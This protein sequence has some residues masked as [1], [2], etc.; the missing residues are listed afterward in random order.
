[1]FSQ[2]KFQNFKLLMFTVRS[3]RWIGSSYVKVA[4]QNE[5]IIKINGLSL[6]VTSD[7][8]NNTTYKTM[9]IQGKPN[10]YCWKYVV[11]IIYT[12][13]KYQKIRIRSILIC[14]KH[15][16]LSLMI[17]NHPKFIW[18]SRIKGILFYYQQIIENLSIQSVDHLVILW[19]GWKKLINQSI[20]KWSSSYVSCTSYIL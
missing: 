2:L 11:L 20:K 19:S 14:L 1:M 8:K 5:Q 18:V 15:E 6:R 12:F 10:W 3:Y 4:I 17:V 13:C 9:T 16:K 7:I